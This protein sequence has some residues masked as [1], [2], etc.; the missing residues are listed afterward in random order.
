[1]K[2]TPQRILEIAGIPTTKENLKKLNEAFEPEESLESLRSTIKQLLKRHDDILSKLESLSLTS[3]SPDL[4]QV[5][6]EAVREREID[7]LRRD[8]A[9]KYRDDPV[10]LK[11]IIRVIEINYRYRL[12]RFNSHSKKTTS[13]SRSSSAKSVMKKIAAGELDYNQV[14][15][16]PATPA[17]MSAAKILKAKFADFLSDREDLQRDGGDEPG[18]DE[19]SAERATEN[20]Y[21]D[22]EEWIQDNYS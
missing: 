14:M 9:R 20:A 8:A 4:T 5:N 6:Y 13:P 10:H 22:L 2:I 12:E 1:M 16:S 15:E 21:F 18:E 19:D 7:E 3:T 17:E 11:R